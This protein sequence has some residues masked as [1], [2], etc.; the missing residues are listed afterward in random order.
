MPITFYGI[1]IKSDKGLKA[2]SFITRPVLLFYNHLFDGLCPSYKI[3]M[4][5][6]HATK[7]MELHLR[8]ARY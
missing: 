7:L 4:G 2:L 6:A 8:C 5:I 3:L 1:T